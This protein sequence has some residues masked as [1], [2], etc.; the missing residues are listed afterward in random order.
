MKNRFSP[1]LLVTAVAVSI[2][3]ATSAFAMPP[4]GNDASGPATGMHERHM[5]HGMKDF[6][7]LHDDLKLDAKQ[8]TLWQEAAKA[9]KDGSMRERI[10]KHHEE[11]Q[12]LLNQPGADLRAVAKRMDDFRAE[13]QKLRNANRDRWLTVYDSLNAGQKEKARLFLKNK[14]D[15]F[16]RDGQRGQSRGGRG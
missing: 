15:R 10:R 9:G 12:S 2:G 3:L 13:G 7:R 11:M 8:E 5:A 14:F 16:G 4:R 6:S 1:R